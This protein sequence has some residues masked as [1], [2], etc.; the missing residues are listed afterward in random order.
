MAKVLH[1]LDI[2]GVPSILSFYHQN[3]GFGNS[4]LIYHEKNT[5]SS[6][7]SRFYQG[8]SFKKFRNLLLYGIFNSRK[9]D[10]IHIH[11]AETLIPVFKLT[12]KKIVLHY[13]G[14]DI[15][16][17]NRSKNKIRIKLR[18]MA[19]L[20]V[21]NAKNMEPKIITSSNVRKEFL[22]NPIDT[23]HFINKNNHKSGKLSITSGNH[24][25]IKT[26]N[27]IKNIGE[28]TIVDLD[29]QNIPYPM[30][31]V[32]LSK[33]EMYI[34]IRIMPWGQTLEELSTTALQAL[35]CGCKIYHNDKI[36]EKFPAE[37][38]PQNVLSRLNG[39][40]EEILERAF[41]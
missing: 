18:S 4:D 38:S 1:V 10:V 26:I 8:R 25:K 35:S 23:S 15:R 20:I 22:P 12:G 7:I 34:D 2:A 39:F 31:P 3:H 41:K 40:Y 24:D 14:S 37:H 30:M 28:T 11:G 16:D 6:S 29:V 36:I 17:P 21:Y 9:Y 27:A 19:D 13:H 33:Y 32:F 5:F